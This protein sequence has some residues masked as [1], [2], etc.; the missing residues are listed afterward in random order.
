[1]EICGWKY[2]RT[3][4]LGREESGKYVEICGWK[5]TRIGVLGR[6]ESGRYMD[7]WMEILQGYW[8]GR[9]WKM[10]TLIPCG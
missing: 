5:Y 7:M 10:G 1:M 2:T 6:E 9:R 4:V 3:G 8:V